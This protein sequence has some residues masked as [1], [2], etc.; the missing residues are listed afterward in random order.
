VTDP[1]PFSRQNAST[2]TDRSQVPLERHLLLL[3]V[4]GFTGNNKGQSLQWTKTNVKLSEREAS[5][6]KGKR[7]KGARAGGINNGLKCGIGPAPPTY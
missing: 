4:L 2:T 5:K 7:S 6:T 1:D 3:I